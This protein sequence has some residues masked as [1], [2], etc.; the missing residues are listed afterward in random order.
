ML[1]LPFADSRQEHGGSLARRRLHAKVGDTVRIFFGDA[2]PSFTSS[3]HII[4]EIF[5]KVHLFGGL[6]SPPL[7]GIQTVTVPPGGVVISEFK[8]HVLV[9]H[10]LSRAE[11]GLV[12][13]LSVD[14][15]PN[16]DIYNGTPMAGMGH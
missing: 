8:L 6:E 10:A 14:G 13:I 12:G 9:D 7:R 16:A 2:G 5:D 4:G 11:R 1:G 15:P 3:F